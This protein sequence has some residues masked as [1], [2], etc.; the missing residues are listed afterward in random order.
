MR[1]QR[2]SV[3]TWKWK[4]CWVRHSSLFDD[5]EGIRGLS[6]QLA[7]D[8]RGDTLTR[9]HISEVLWSTSF[10][11]FLRVYL[12]GMR[13]FNT[14]HWEGHNRYF[15]FCLLQTFLMNIMSVVKEGVCH[16]CSHTSC[17]LTK[18]IK[19]FRCPGCWKW[20]LQFNT[21]CCYI[22]ENVSAVYHLMVLV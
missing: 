20:T 8:E 9:C 15:F 10:S 7:W 18:K 3:E 14:G 19:D 12:K 5:E 6:L 21:S 11:L 16:L 22:G 17:L 2:Y 4:P 1:T 13:V